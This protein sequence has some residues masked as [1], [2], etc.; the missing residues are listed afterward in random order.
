MNRESTPTEQQLE[1][2]GVERLEWIQ[3]KDW[4]FG[5]DASGR[6]WREIGEP[7]GWTRRDQKWQTAFYDEM[8]KVKAKARKAGKKDRLTFLQSLKGKGK[9]KEEKDEDDWDWDFQEEL[10]EVTRW[11][12]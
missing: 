3:S 9:D 7:K 1:R 8:M 10:E 4:A 2:D 12:G 5:G 6:W 11:S